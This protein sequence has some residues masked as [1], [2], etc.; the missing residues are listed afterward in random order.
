LALIQN[1]EID[2]FEERVVITDFVV[3]VE[4]VSLNGVFHAVLQL[5]GVL[6]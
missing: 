1:R 3:T 5:A 6:F 2:S 4:Y